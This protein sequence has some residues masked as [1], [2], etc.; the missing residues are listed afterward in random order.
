MK[1]SIKRREKMELISCCDVNKWFML[2]ENWCHFVF[3]TEFII[4]EP[5]NR[6]NITWDKG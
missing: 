5:L 4:I 6:Q 3:Q 2:F 1:N